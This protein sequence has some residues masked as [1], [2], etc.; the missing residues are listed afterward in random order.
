MR[1]HITLFLGIFSVMALSNAIV[2]VLPSYASESSWSGAIY[3]AYF[4]GAFI[5]TMPAGFLSD[6]Y[7]RINLMRIGLVVTI[8]SGA[9]LCWTTATMPAL[10]ARLIEGIGAGLFV[11]PAMSYVNAGKDHERMSGYLLALLNAGLVLGLVFA[12]L[13]AS[14][15]G[16]PVAGILLFTAL[17]VIPAGVSLLL[18]EPSSVAGTRPDLRVFFTFARDYRWLWYSSVVLVGITGVVTSLYPKFSGASTDL[19]GI[20]IAAMSIATIVAVLIISRF[21]FNGY[22]AIRIAAVLMMVAVLISYISPAG[23][24]LIGVLAGIVM[25]AQ[26]GILARVAEHQ[27][28][29]MGLFTMTSY[30]GMALLPFLAGLVAAS[31]GFFPAFFVTALLAVTVAL[32]IGRH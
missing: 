18:K 6:R 20:W 12:G 11:A 22:R 14:F 27:G 4:L 24:I 7:G 17:T 5:S 8:A 19:L 2:P 13:L 16:T 1:S 31:G 15:T 32:P 10:W 29:V 30:L 23:F 26:M 28:T 25:I 21:P 3:S 9:F